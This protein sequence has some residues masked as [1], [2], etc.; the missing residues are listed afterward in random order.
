MDGER[1]DGSLRSFVL[2]GLVGVSAGIATARRL[3][4]RTRRPPAPA[5][6]AA[7]EEAPCYLELVEGGETVSRRS[8]DE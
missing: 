3:R 2:G 5:G 8:K 1:K 7:F 4:P 6:L